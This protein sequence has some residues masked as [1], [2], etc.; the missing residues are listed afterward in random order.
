[1]CYLI[2]NPNPSEGEL[3]FTRY[4]R[5]TFYG[6]DWKAYLDY[7]TREERFTESGEVETLRPESGRKASLS[8]STVVGD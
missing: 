2:A 7:T 3:P 6:I 8:L 5:S 4:E 1:M